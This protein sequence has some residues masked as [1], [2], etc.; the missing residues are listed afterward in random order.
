M[1]I[2]VTTLG[3]KYNKEWIFRN[4]TYTFHS[5]SRYAVT[6]NN[7][8]GKSTLLQCLSGASTINAGNVEWNIEGKKIAPENV[9]KYFS[10][11]APS[12]DIVEEMTPLEFLKFHA[13]F[14][15]FQKHMDFS[16]MIDEIQLAHA[17]D[18]QI[19][20]FSSGMRQ[21]VKLAQC[22]FSDVPVVML[23]EPCTNLDKSGIDLYHS[24]VQ[25][26]TAGKLVFVSSNDPIEYSFC[27]QQLNIMEYK[28]SKL[29]G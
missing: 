14:K 17:K 29:K 1:D 7:G 18:K 22:L 28:K 24:L 25:K 8:S 9:F 26:Y 11:A 5:G 19:R 6:G 21:R 16:E 2:A 13:S 27:D 12:M 10:F 20:F 4:L 23:D 3:K 15:P